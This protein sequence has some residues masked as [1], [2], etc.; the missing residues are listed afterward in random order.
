MKSLMITLGL[1]NQDYLKNMASSKKE[2]RAMQGEVKTMRANLQNFAKGMAAI[3]AAITAALG[4]AVQQTITAGDE[5]QKMS[6]RTGFGTESLSKL[7]YAADQSGS[8]LDDVEKSAK[9]LA[10]VMLDA[11]QGL[12]TANDSFKEIGLTTKDLQGMRPEDQFLKVANAVAR[13]EDPMKKAAVAQELFGR[14]GTKLLPLLAEGEQGMEALMNRADELGIVWTEDA[15]NAAVKF[16]DA[17]DDLKKSVQG[18]AY[19]VG[20]SLLNTLQPLID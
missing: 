19:S 5:I 11:D 14:A 16:G 20:T 1:K 8:S 3:S 10:A 9:R 13:V 15:A 2:L 18:V 17:L 7:K 4:L 12:K 6:L